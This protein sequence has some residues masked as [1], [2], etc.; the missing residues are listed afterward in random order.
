MRLAAL[1]GVSVCVLV[2]A[3]AVAA[4][5]SAPTV[6]PGSFWYRDA[7]CETGH[8]GAPGDGKPRW[9]WGSKH[10]PLEGSRYEGG[11]GFA[12]S[13]WRWWGGEV[14]AYPKYRHA[15]LAPPYLQAR[16]AEW[17]LTHEGKWGCVFKLT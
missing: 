5:T 17:G 14:G 16:A 11:I 6:P 2:F 12:P 3:T 7:V 10:R 15:Y 13:T 4:A 9:D 1:T 8:I